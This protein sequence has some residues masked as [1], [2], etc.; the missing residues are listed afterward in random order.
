LISLRKSISSMNK[1]GLLVYS[2]IVMGIQREVNNKSYLETPFS[3]IGDR[4]IDIIKRI[5]IKL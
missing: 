1:N 5:V 2:L 4:E 3:I